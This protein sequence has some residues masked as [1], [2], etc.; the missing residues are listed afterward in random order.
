M[1]DTQIG[2]NFSH[3]ALRMLEAGADPKEVVLKL[4]EVAEDLYER[5]LDAQLELQRISK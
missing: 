1:K 2:I 3:G 5:F 4:A